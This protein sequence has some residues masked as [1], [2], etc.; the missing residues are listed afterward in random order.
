MTHTLFNLGGNTSLVLCREHRNDAMMWLW[1]EYDGTW[2]ATVTGHAQCDACA[3]RA[4]LPASFRAALR[5]QPA[6]LA[7]GVPPPARFDS[8][9]SL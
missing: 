9:L 8:T 6:T 7:A 2:T 4:Q 5:R 3:H 1:H